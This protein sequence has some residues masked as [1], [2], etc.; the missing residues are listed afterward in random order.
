MF[1]NHDNRDGNVLIIP[2]ILGTRQ[3]DPLKKTLFALAH[4]Q[5]LC[6]IINNFP[7]CSFP[8]ITNDTHII[9]PPFIVSSEY[10]HFEIKFH[11]IS[12]FIQPQKICNMVP[13]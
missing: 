3:N 10:E 6:S 7:S 2:F 8:S 9:G 1:Y 13:L 4:L 11:V 5:A 12:L